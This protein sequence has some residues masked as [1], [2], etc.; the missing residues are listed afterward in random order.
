MRLHR[1]LR[2][3]TTAIAATLLAASVATA[4]EY[5]KLKAGQWDLTLDRGK[6]A[7][8]APPM[9]TTMC[10]DDAVQRE[11]MTMGAGMTRDTCTKLEFKRDGARFLGSAECKFGESKMTSRSVMTLTGDTAYRTEINATFDPPFMGMKDSQTTLEGK[12]A[13]PCK[14]GMVPGDILTAG[15]QKFN[16]KNIGQGKAA[17][18]AKSAPTPSATQPAPAKKAAQ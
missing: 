16:V 6:A 5:P 15:G 8:G 1:S 13:G 2:I 14:D 17:P 18:A 3:C 9:K 12:F 7:N 10:T 4:Q 11:M